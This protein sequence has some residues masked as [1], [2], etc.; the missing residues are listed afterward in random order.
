MKGQYNTSAAPH[1]ELGRQYETINEARDRDAMILMKKVQ[2]ICLNPGISNEM[3]L[4]AMLSL[5][6]QFDPKNAKKYSAYA[7][8]YRNRGLT[9]Y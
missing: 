2:G 8:M 1:I 3:K 6:M 4:D 5:R 7:E 9:A